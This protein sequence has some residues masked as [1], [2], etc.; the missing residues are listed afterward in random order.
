[1]TTIDSRPGAE[2]ERLRASTSSRAGPWKA[3]GPWLS[4]RAWG[5]VREDYSAD[6]DAWRYFPHEHS[7]SRAY[8]WNEDGLAGLC[9]LDQ[10]ICFALAFWNGRDPILKERIYGLAGPEGNHGEDAKEYWWYV[11]ATP[12]ASW[13]RWRYHYPQAEFP[14]SRLR[15]EN[16]RRGRRDREFEL[17]DSGVFD[18]GRYW[19]LTADYAKAS[20]TDVCIRL[21]IRNSGPEPADLHVLPTLWFRNRWSWTDGAPR[22][23]IRAVPSATGAVALSLAEGEAIDRWALAAGPQPDGMLPRLLFCENETNAPRL[24]GAAPTTPYPKDG[25]NDHVIHGAATVNPELCGTKMSCWYRLRVGARETVELRLRFAKLEGDA[26]PD[27]GA[28]YVRAL[29]EREGEADEFYEAIRPQQATDEEAR[30]MRQAFAGMIW[31]QQFYHFDVAKWLDGDRVSPPAARRAGRNAGWRHVDNHDVIAMPDKWEYPWYAAWDLAFHC[32]VLAHV[33]PAAAKHQLLLLCREWYMHPNGQ[34]PAYEWSFGDVNPP[35]HAWAALTV[36]AIDGSRDFDFL[37][38]AFHKLLINFTWWVN[39][40][41]A[42]GDNIFEGGFLG[43]DNIGAFDRSTPLPGGCVVEQSDG[44]AW[45]AKYCLNMLEIALR[46]ANRNRAYEDVALKFFEHFCRIARAARELWSDDDGFFYDRLRMPDGRAI[47]LKARSMVGLLPLFAAVRIDEAL[48]EALPDFRA[49]SRWFIRHNPWLKEFL[50]FNPDD[51]RPMLLSLLDPGQLRRVLGRMLDEQEFL[52]PHGLR[53][54]S[55]YH[56]E[57]PL[58][59]QL[60]GGEARLDYEPGESETGLFGGNSNWRGPVWFP[61]N[62]LALESLRH[63]DACLGKEFEVELP[64]GSGRTA[65]LAQVADELERRLLTL[66]LRDERGHRPAG[67]V[68]DAFRRDPEWPDPILFHE[69]F[70]GDTGEGLGASH[71][72]GWTALAGALIADRRR[73]KGT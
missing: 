3:L 11:D 38:R 10:R 70:H 52:A 23:S 1:M 40:K 8:R 32:V 34:L 47:P 56:Q 43:L 45:M 42:F 41:D 50:R 73:R 28:T 35:V 20:P 63:L 14:Y 65:A 54:L 46:L 51:D 53:S 15:E 33:D 39:R 68:P 4:E 17:A 59:V 66:F 62:F 18:D 31:S 21:R 69:Y 55:R 19:S 22:P 71:Q 13:L 24:F 29:Q 61:L 9:D 60:P 58:V 36:F 48:W 12:T 26:V 72:T 67:G 27:L 64:T 30:V 44:T 16:A 37:A 5:T 57:H 2:F 25:I 49:R 7:R 6:G